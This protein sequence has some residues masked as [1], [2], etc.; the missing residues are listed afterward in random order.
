MTS[1]LRFERRGR[2]ALLVLDRP[3]RLNAI[4]S[5][6]VA[7]L[8]QHLDA[9]EADPQ[10]RSI[11]VTGEGRAFSAG[12]DISELDT[13]QNG[14]DFARFVKGLTDAY[15]RLEACP[16]PSIAAINGMAFGG[17]CE[18]AL[19]C[20]LRL[21]APGARLGVPEIKLG[22]LPAAGGSQRLARMLPA[23][24]AKHMLLTGAPLDAATAAQFGLVNSIHDDVV[25]AALALATSLAE[26]PPAALAAAKRLVDIGGELSLA[27]GIALERD[28]VAALFDTHDRVEG[29]TAFRE[30]RPPSFSGR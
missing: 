26:G 30:K 22:L 10:L 28:T 25:E 5:D 12:A 3:T 2:V 14:A 6:T 29:L 13:L 7:E 8:H 20:D 11:V 18:L 16:V 24:V 19:A 15:D 4:G 17:G 21:A 23:G 9:I 1:V 27:E